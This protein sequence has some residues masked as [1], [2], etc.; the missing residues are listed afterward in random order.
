MY[1]HM[2]DTTQLYIIL[3]T[4]ER[5][6]DAQHIILKNIFLNHF[7]KYGIVSC[8]RVKRAARNTKPGTGFYVCKWLNI[9]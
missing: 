8:H 7:M 4:F 6:Y 5:F 1:P 2:S 3:F 9:Q